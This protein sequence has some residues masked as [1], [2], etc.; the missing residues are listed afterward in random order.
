MKEYLLVQSRLTSKGDKTYVTKVRAS[1]LALRGEGWPNM[2]RLEWTPWVSVWIVL[3]DPKVREMIEVT[4]DTWRTVID[5]RLELV[6]LWEEQEDTLMR[7]V[8]ES[9]KKRSEAHT[10]RPSSR[11]RVH[12]EPEKPE[13]R[14]RPQRV[15]SEKT[16]RP[17]RRARRPE[18]RSS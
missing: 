1:F 2:E 3:A 18:R 12:R 17:T 6:R 5:N 10:R 11:H 14:Q 13:Q 16:E 4:R 7:I 8:K 9:V 15:Q